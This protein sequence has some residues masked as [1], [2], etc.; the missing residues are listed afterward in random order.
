MSQW[1]RIKEIKYSTLLLKRKRLNFSKVF[2]YEEFEKQKYTCA[3][4]R[5]LLRPGKLK[6][7]PKNGL[8]FYAMSI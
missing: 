5:V 7:R 8:A 1:W 3:G 4:P 2:S 6:Y